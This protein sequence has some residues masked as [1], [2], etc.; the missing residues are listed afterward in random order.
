MMYVKMKEG[1]NLI[2]AQ[3]GSSDQSWNILSEFESENQLTAHKL[4]QVGSYIGILKWKY[5]GKLTKECEKRE[6]KGMRKMRSEKKRKNAQK[7]AEEKQKMDA[8][9]NA[10]K[11]QKKNTKQNKNGKKKKNARKKN[12]K[13]KEESEESEEE[14]TEE[15]SVKESEES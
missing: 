6:E 4:V 13:K 12:A 3:G 1:S 2:L 14:E 11:Q 9:K 15:E 7:H 10:K 5:D 8:K